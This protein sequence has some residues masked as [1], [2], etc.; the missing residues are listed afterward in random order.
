MIMVASALER[1]GHLDTDR[2]GPVEDLIKRYESKGWAA[3][4]KQKSSSYI[5]LSLGGDGEAQ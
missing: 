2:V 3:K 1:K 5:G 4:M